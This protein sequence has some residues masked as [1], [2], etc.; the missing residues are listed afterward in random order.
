M[1]FSA[2][3]QATKE[4]EKSAPKV[5]LKPLCPYLSYELLDLDH[6]FLVIVSAN[7]MTPNLKNCWMCSR[8][9]GVLSVTVLMVLRDLVLHYACIASFLIKAINPLDN[10]S[11]A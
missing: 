2:E 4:K 8:S 11:A 5:E 1:V 3:E 7:W 9:I 6:R 10:L